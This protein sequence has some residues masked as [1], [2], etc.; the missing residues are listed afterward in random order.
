MSNA[1]ISEDRKKL[2][3]KIRGGLVARG[4]SF[5]AWCKERGVKHQNAY[6]AV[7]GVWGGPKASALVEELKQAAGVSE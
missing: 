7:M 1:N 6:Q 4:T 2:H 5:T 3:S